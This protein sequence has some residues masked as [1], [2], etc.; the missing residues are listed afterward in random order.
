[1]TRLTGWM[2]LAAAVGAVGLGAGAALADGTVKGK[3]NFDGKMAKPKVVRVSTDAF[4]VQAHQSEPLLA[5]TY[6]FNFEKSTLCNVVVWVKGPVSGNFEVPS[7]PVVIDQVGCQYIPHV[8]GTMVGQTVEMHNSDDTAHNL[9]FT[10][11]KNGQFN[12][13]QPVKG[14]V[15]DVKFSNPETGMHLA[16]NVHNWM[17]AHIFAF[18]HPFF[19]VSDENGEYEIKG[20][21]AG[22]YTLTVWHEFDKFS[23]VQEEIEV[24]VKDGETAEVDFTYKPPQ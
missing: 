5:E 24:E 12:E 20:L 19:A 21:P 7:K 16:C 4:C 15:K 9:K 10:S 1:M 14:M 17:N 18:D 22:K 3:I 11:E 8:V 6:V 23:P 2:K 13:G